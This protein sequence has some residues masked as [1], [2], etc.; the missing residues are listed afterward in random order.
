MTAIGERVL[1]ALS[2][3]PGSDDFTPTDSEISLA[4][5]LYLLRRVYPNLANLVA[6]K[7]VLDFGCGQGHQSIALTREMDC[8]VVGV[9]TNEATLRKAR[10]HAAAQEIPP[11]RLSFVTRVPAEMRGTFDVVISQNAF[12]HFAEPEATLAEMRQS[13]SKDGVVLLTFGP[14]WFAP[15]GNHMYFF[16][17][18]PWMNVLFAEK[19][20]MKVR[21]SFRS[22][23][24]RRYEDVESGLNRM[25]VARF[26]RI[27]R[28][29]QLELGA[30]H[31]GCIRGMDWLAKLPL[32]RELFINHVTA[33]LRRAA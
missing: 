12:E 21:S 7:R 28:A 33:V 4:D 2:R 18:V 22:D 14:P 5:P 29:A 30:T 9:D 8:S 26:E 20:V 27:V 31:Y 23:D 17:K 13:L 19:T 32:T 6:L 3:T 24:A 25:T 15:Y 11:N 16:S 10:R 1:R